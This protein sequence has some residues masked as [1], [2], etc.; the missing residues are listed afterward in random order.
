MKQSSVGVCGVID[1]M[2]SLCSGGEGFS[3]G[4]VD[5]VCVYGR[6]AILVHKKKAVLLEGGFRINPRKFHFP[7]VRSK[8]REPRDMFV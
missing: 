2:A 6:G 7:R 3:G 5:G 4:R 8:P 1:F